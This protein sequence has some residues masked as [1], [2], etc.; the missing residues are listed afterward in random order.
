MADP[1]A[2]AV[3]LVDV[4][5]RIGIV[6]VPWRTWL[7]G[8]SYPFLDLPVWPTAQAEQWCRTSTAVH[9]LAAVHAVTIRIRDSIGTRVAAKHK[10]FARAMPPIRSIAIGRRVVEGCVTDNHCDASPNSG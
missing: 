9:E 1:N 2:V 7:A 6:D 4:I 10:P 3:V 5:G 8:L